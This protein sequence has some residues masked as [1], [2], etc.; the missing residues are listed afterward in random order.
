MSAALPLKVLALV[1]GGKDSTYAVLECLRENHDVVCLGNLEPVS[2]VDELDSF[3]YQTVGHQGVHHL[4]EAME[5][6]LLRK[7]IQRQCTCGD[8]G[9]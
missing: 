2:G 6:P 3:M 5:L 8:I 1:S 4:S 7:T 9:V